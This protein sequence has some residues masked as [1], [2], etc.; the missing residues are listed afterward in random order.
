MSS[1]F[2]SLTNSVAGKCQTT[3]IFSPVGYVIVQGKLRKI[4]ILVNW[5]STS[6]QEDETGCDEGISY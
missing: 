4:M 5:S 3:Q 6:F 2:R 1:D